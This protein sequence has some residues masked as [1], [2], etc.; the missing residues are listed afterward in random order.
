MAI[1]AECDICGLQHRVKDGLAGSSIRCKDCGVQF[2]V[3]PGPVI[4]PETYFEDGGR[5]R[6]REPE[7]DSNRV[8][9]RIVAGL[10]AGLII[11][12]LAGAVWAFTALIRPVATLTARKV[13]AALAPS[14]CVRIPARQE[15]CGEKRLCPG[16]PGAGVRGFLVSSSTPWRTVILQSS[17]SES[18]FR[19]ADS[20][21]C[22]G[23]VDSQ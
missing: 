20:S 16:A 8:W 15:P 14:R 21:Q 6:L 12:A 22:E 2:A 9:P 4:S 18:L 23:A 3:R 13:G 11:A 7:S 5:L 1:L 10:V 17:S 19:I